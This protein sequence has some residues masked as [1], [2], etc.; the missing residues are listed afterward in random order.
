MQLR[1]QQVQLKAP[2]G[3]GKLI[4]DLSFDVATGE[5]IAVIGPAGSGK[6]AVFRLLNRLV[7]PSHGKIQFEGR[8]LPQWP[9]VEVRRQIALIGQMPRLLGMDVRTALQY[10]LQLQSLPQSEHAP[11]IADTCERLA[12][13][14]AWLDHTARELTLGQQQIVAIARSLVLQPKVLLLDG[15]LATLDSGQ[16]ARLLH[17]LVQSSPDLTLL[18]TSHELDGVGDCC[19]RYIVLH[20]GKLQQDQAA[21]NLDRDALKQWLKQTALN[22]AAAWQ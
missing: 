19:D 15:P 18:L 14:Q 4:D 12:I 20:Q 5:R 13:P 6:T 22:E 10:P 17:R 21:S 9:I 1:L 8:D 11:R 3:M 2:I 16:L 7:D